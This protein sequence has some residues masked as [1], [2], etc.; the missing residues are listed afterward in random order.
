MK[1]KVRSYS[2]PHNYEF[3]Y[4]E[5]EFLMYSTTE[6]LAFARKQIAQV[7]GTNSFLGY[8]IV[9]TK[10]DLIYRLPSY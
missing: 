7:R 5:K 4:P 6:A 8:K 9:N 1:V 2:N 10:G 3:D